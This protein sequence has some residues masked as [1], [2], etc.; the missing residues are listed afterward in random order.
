MKDNR[1]GNLIPLSI[2]PPYILQSAA[3]GQGGGTSRC[4]NT[5]LSFH[6]YVP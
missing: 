5:V 6:P 4:L 1:F 2:Y 3:P